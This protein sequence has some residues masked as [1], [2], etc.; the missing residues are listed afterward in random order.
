MIKRSIGEG[1]AS[2]VVESPGLKRSCK[3]V[4]ACHHEESL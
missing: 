3:R 4:D 2:L 1:V